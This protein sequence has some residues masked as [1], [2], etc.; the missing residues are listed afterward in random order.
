[1]EEKID[2][3]GIQIGGWEVITDMEKEKIWIWTVS[4]GQLMKS[5]SARKTVE[6]KFPFLEG[7]L[8]VLRTF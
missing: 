8:M 3:R 1:M 6:F 7:P 2:G 4:H 5:S